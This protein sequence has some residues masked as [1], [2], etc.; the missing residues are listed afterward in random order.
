MALAAA[1]GPFLGGVL[2]ELWGWPAVYWVRVPIALATL[3]LS[4]LLPSPKPDVAAV[5]CAGRAS[6]S[7]P[8]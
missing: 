2:V 1:I 5:R 3:A 7:R 8:A 6:C 4:G